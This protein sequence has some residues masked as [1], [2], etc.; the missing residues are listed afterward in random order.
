M[1]DCHKHSTQV[2]QVPVNKSNENMIYICP[3]HPEIRETKPGNCPK[4][5]MALEPEKIIV[6]EDAKNLELIDFQRR[7]WIGIVL[8]LPLLVLEMG[9]HLFDLHLLDNQLS[10]WVQFVLATPV[11][12]WVGFP[13]FKRGYDSVLNRSLN[14][15]TLVAMGTGVAWVYSVIAVFMPGIFPSAF[16][17]HGMVPVYFEAA[18]VI[19]VLVLLGQVLELKAR[20][21]TGGA[22]KALL[23]LAPKRRIALMVKM[24]K[25]LQL[26]IYS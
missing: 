5:G 3:M 6:D 10:A 13:F 20:E 19:I 11:V 12:W 24:K 2:A 9:G 7:L 25:K 26:K 16:R 8:T 23:G 15:F 14:M 22:I 21:K 17:S 18:A 1:K 4:C